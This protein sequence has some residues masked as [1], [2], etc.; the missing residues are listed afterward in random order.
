MNFPNEE[1][2]RQDETL[3]D[4]AIVT[5]VAAGEIALFELLMRRHNQR[6]YRTIRSVIR[7]EA[8]VEDAMQQTYVNAYRNLAQFAGDAKFS[9]WLLKIALHE[10]FARRRRK[11]FVIAESDCGEPCEEAISN[12]ESASRTPEADAANAELKAILERH[13][14]DLHENYRV[15]FV[16]RDVEGL[17]TEE[18]AQALDVST[19][20][21]KTRLHR[22]R[23]MLRD[24]LVAKAGLT[25]DQLFEFRDTRCSRVVNAVMAE[26]T[27]A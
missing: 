26:I 17:S 15:V 11:S 23:A 5:R 25:A 1:Q 27:R 24:A 8:E 19:D 2:R 22:A 9:T 4:E 6:V 10:A 16:M 3:A 13:I 14:A 18:T 20:V 12:V 7:N 21:V